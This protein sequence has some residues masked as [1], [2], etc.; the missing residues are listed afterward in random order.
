MRLG[1]YLNECAGSL[2]SVRAGRPRAI[3]FPRQTFNEMVEAQPNAP[4]V[5][6]ERQ[7]ENQR[8]TQQH[9][10]YKLIVSGNDWQRNHIG[11]N[12]DCLG[13]DYGD[14]DCAHEESLFAFED[15][16]ARLTTLFDVK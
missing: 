13:A 9:S 1:G 5:V 7:R 6:V 3:A 12:N 8:E 11:Q 16:S 4:T 14:H 15:G 10:D 2:R